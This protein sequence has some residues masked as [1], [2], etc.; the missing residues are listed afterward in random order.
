[1][2]FALIGYGRMGR[3]IELEAK[4]RNHTIIVTIDEDK[5]VNE[6]TN[7]DIFAN[8]DVCI[9]FSIPTAV[10]TTV[11]S[12]AQ[13]GTDMVIGTTGW[14]D[15]LA[16]IKTLAETNQFGIIYAPNFSLGINIFFEIVEC[17]ATMLNP[18]PQY[19]PWIHEWH[20]A[21]KIDNPSGTALHLAKEVIDRL[22][23]KNE[24]SSGNITGK[25]PAD[26]LHISSIRSGNAPGTH[27]VGF[28]SAVDTITLTHSARDRTGFARGAVTAA[29]WITGRIG[30]FTMRDLLKSLQN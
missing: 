22:D 17:A 20:H 15:H 30:L 24:I 6:S 7:L 23:Q 4:A 12:I 18:F 10:P 26:H 8:V 16:E 13:T 25:I 14:Y 11:R 29:E 28:D 2:N 27:T 3:A 19:D 5:P 21:N 9:D 1:M